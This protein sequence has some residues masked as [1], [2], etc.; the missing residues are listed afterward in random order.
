MYNASKWALEGMSEAL[1][2]EVAPFGIHVPSSN[3]APAALPRHVPLSDRRRGLPEAA[4][5]LAGLEPPRDAGVS[6]RDLL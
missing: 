3:P 2:Q 5:H 6:G 4:R 1:A